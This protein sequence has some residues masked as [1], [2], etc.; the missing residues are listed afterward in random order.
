MS[1]P[2]V[3]TNTDLEDHAFHSMVEMHAIRYAEELLI[4]KGFEYLSI[5]SMV[6][7]ETIESQGLVSWDHSLK[8]QTN[9]GEFALSGSAEQGLLE[10]FRGHVVAPS[11]WFATNQCF[12][13]ESTTAAN[14]RLLE[15]RKVEQFGFCS[16]LNDVSTTMKDFLD[17]ATLIYRRAFEMSRS[18]KGDKIP[19]FRLFECSD[20][21]GGAL[22]K[23][24]L[25]YLHTNGSWL[26]LASCTYYGSELAERFDIKGATDI[27]SCTAFASPRGLFL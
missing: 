20:I 8:V 7:R 24:D 21:T 9:F 2:H 13:N 15:F 12:R 22:K 26:E 10:F 23:V 17:N 14:F 25:E 18:L 5:P 16:N 6:T 19:D 3:F 4:G 1:N 27:V 11:Y